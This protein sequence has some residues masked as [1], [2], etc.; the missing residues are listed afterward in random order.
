LDT[1][2]IEKENTAINPGG[3]HVRPLVTRPTPELDQ[4][5]LAT[6]MGEANVADLADLT[7]IARVVAT[8]AE[9]DPYSAGQLEGHL[10]L[11]GFDQ[12]QAVMGIRGL[13]VRTPRSFYDA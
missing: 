8:T 7:H 9:G 5:F 6:V 10:T 11:G 1:V 2:R 4:R 12:F 13:N 3:G